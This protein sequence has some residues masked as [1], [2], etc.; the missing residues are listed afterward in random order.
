[1]E[2]KEIGSWSFKGI[3]HGGWWE[4]WLAAVARMFRHYGR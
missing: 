3:A 4:K 2:K 1:M